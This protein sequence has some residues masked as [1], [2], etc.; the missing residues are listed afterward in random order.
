[1]ERQGI[2][3]MMFMIGEL[4]EDIKIEEIRLNTKLR[5]NFSFMLALLL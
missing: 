5:V 3:M 1:M 2:R 4:N